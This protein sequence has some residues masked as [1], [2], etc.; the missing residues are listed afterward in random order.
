MY[1]LHI[2]RVMVSTNLFEFESL[3]PKYPYVAKQALRNQEAFLIFC[4]LNL[5]VILSEYVFLISKLINFKNSK[6]YVFK[7]L[8]FFNFFFETFSKFDH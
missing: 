8:E 7:V 5:K 6:K 2:R 1:S 3:M 4:G